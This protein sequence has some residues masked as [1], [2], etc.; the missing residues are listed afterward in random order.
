MWAP[1]VTLQA[2]PTPRGMELVGDGILGGLAGGRQVE[3]DLISLDV[4]LA[5]PVVGRRANRPFGLTRDI[6]RSVLGLVGTSHSQA[7]DVR[8]AIFPDN[9]D[10]TPWMFTL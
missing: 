2:G 6:V 5:L 4:V 8:G 9:P 3:R 7:S 10:T 1:R